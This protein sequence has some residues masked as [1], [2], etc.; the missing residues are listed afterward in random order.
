MSIT[1]AGYTGQGW[2]G[3]GR[4]FMVT[5]VGSAEQLGHETVRPG[6]DLSV[7]REQ[8]PWWASKGGFNLT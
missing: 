4:P 1:A 3:Q 6:G 7:G 2:S 8:D 5:V